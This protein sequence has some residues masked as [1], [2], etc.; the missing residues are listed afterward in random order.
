[1]IVWKKAEVTHECPY[2]VIKELGFQRY[3]NNIVQALR[4]PLAFEI[5]KKLTACEPK[6]I[7][8]YSTSEGLYLMK[9]DFNYN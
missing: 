9:R 6:N 5:I 1:M 2:E 8:I 7:T 3:E 4:E